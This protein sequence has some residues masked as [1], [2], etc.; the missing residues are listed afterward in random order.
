MKTASKSLEFERAALLRDQI[1]E[2]RRDLQGD[3]LAVDPRHLVDG[4]PQADGVVTVTASVATPHGQ[5]VAVGAG[6][7]ASRAKR[8][9]R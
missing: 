4:V 7:P 8:G 3:S 9:R 2:L 5:P 1:V 6:R